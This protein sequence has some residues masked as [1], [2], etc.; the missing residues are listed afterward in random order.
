MLKIAVIGVLLL[1]A[2]LATKYLDER[3]QKKLLIALGVLV[4]C[5]VAYLMA[6]ELMR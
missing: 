1:L 4:G 6:I 2:F 3:R 5:A